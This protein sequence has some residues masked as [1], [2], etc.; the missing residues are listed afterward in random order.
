M[1]AGLTVQ[2]PI[3]WFERLEN[4]TKREV[5]VTVARQRVVWAFRVLGEDAWEEKTQPS[6]EHWD[7]LLQKMKDRYQRRRATELDMVLV[8]RLHKQAQ[9]LARTRASIPRPDQSR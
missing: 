7:D 4:G 8:T 5:Q 1:T 6:A 2:S 3:N 9:D